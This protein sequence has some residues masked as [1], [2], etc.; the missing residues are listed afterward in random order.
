MRCRM[1]L[2]LATLL[3]LG[4]T[5]TQAAQSAP[6]G[7]ALAKEGSDLYHKGA[8]AAAL[9]KLDAALAAGR[10]DAEVLYM[11]G[12]CYR[13]ALG[14]TAKE[15]E[16][17]Q[18]AVPLLEREVAAGG[19]LNSHFY[20]ASIYIESLGDKEKG[21]EVAR[22]GIAMAEKSKGAVTSDPADHFRLGRLHTFA[23]D[24]AG[25]AAQYGEYLKLTGEAGPAQDQTSHRAALSSVAAYRMAAKE[26]AGAAEAYSALLD[27][28]PGD[29]QI[30]DLAA[31]AA[32]LAGDPKTAAALWRGAKSDE[33]RTEYMYFAGVATRY[34]G[35]GSPAASKLA[36]DA[37]SL[38]DPA[39]VEKIQAAAK[40]FGELRSAYL[41]EKKEKEDKAQAARQAEMDAK[42]NL[43]PEEI[44]ARI[45]AKKKEREAEMAQSGGGEGDPNK[46]SWQ[47]SYEMHMAETNVT[48][49]FPEPPAMQAAAKDFYFLMHEYVKRG[50]PLREFC[51]Q[52]GLVDLVFR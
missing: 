33:K 23:G 45:Q 5:Q 21:S 52:Y 29:D 31:R 15:R 22:K 24:E 28:D 46:P 30:R 3:I 26:H 41:R 18:R 51:F 11:A 6:D 35:H 37:A 50:H 2:S 13:Q 10:E 9:K 14:N 27:L 47:R 16:L 49:E 1:V 43:T 40:V 44:K 42:K 8:Y 17:K 38:S 7:A 4:L 25:A 36:P 39:L 48:V 34:A 20:L 19:T 32:L 12:A